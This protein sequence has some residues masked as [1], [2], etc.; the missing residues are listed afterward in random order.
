MPTHALSQDLVS[1]QSDIAAASGRLVRLPNFAVVL[2]QGD[3]GVPDVHRVELQIGF[4]TMT[5]KSWPCLIRYADA[6]VLVTHEGVPLNTGDV[7]LG[8]AISTAINTLRKTWLHETKLEIV[9]VACREPDGTVTSKPAPARHDVFADASAVS[10]FGFGT[11]AGNF[12]S[13]ATAARIAHTGNQLKRNRVYSE[14][15]VLISEDVW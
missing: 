13:R 9:G 3:A 10:E 14:G 1:F 4:G 12:V 6:G 15:D 2:F 7:D 5:T 8:S 11:V